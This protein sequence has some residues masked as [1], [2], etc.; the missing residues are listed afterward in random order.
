M[1]IIHTIPT[2]DMR[3]AEVW[4]HVSYEHKRHTGEWFALNDDVNRILS[5]TEVYATSE[6]FRSQLR[7]CICGMIFDGTRNQHAP[8]CS[9][10]CQQGKQMRDCVVCGVTFNARQAVDYFF[11][12]TYCEGIAKD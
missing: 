12:S 5:M 1:S 4:L 2:D 9:L 11:C 7:R 10:L 6:T 3:G 8:Y